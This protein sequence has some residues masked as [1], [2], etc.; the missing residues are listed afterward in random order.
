MAFIP[1]KRLF[2]YVIS[3]IVVLAAGSLGLLALR[4][5]PRA[6]TD[7]LVIQADG[8]AAALNVAPGVLAG[9]A[10]TTSTESTTTSTTPAKIWV[11]VAGAV[12]RPGVYQLFEGARVFEAVSAAGGFASN[13]DQESTALAAQLSDGCRVY[14]PRKGEPASGQVQA[15]VQ[16]S[17]G[18]SE[19]SAGP[20]GGGKGLSS[21]GLVLLNSATLEQLDSL[22]GVGPAL[23]QQI[24]SYREKNGPFTSVDQ[25][26]D[27]PGIGPAKLEQLRP[28][29]GL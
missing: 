12:R 9:G 14:V 3:G 29:V 5:G 13:A 26:D 19:G 6:S 8:A 17:A 20:G 21:T 18:L 1:T 7:A 15:P 25:L 16:S 23:A 28:L 11:Q 10:A 27:V 2:V 22:P 24:L 4:D